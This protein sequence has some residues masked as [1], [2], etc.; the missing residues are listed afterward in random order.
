MSSRLWSVFVDAFGS[1]DRSLRLEDLTRRD[2]YQ[3]TSDKLNGNRQFVKMVNEASVYPSLI[4]EVTQRARGV[5]LWVYL[6]V[7]DL[8]RGLTNGDSGNLLQSRLEMFPEDLDEFFRHMITTIPPMYLQ[9]T[10]RLFEIVKSASEPQSAIALSFVDEVEAEPDLPQKS[11]IERM[12][13]SEIQ[14]RFDQIRRRLDARSKGLLEITSEDSRDSYFRS[15]I[16]FLHRTVYEFL[17]RSESLGA[18]SQENRFSNSPSTALVMCKAL[19]VTLKRA[20]G[21]PIDWEIYSSVFE[22]ARHLNSESESQKKLINTLREAES[23]YDEVY[24]YET[25]QA[26]AAVVPRFSELACA[27][28]ILLFVESE[29]QNGGYHGTSKHLALDY[30]LARRTVLHPGIIKTL[31]EAEADPNAKIGHFTIFGR[32]MGSIAVQ[33]QPAANESIKDVLHLLL[34]SGADV[35]TTVTSRRRV[36]SSDD[37]D[38]GI[39][40]LQRRRCLYGEEM[41]LQYNTSRA[42]QVIQDCF[43]EED[44]IDMSDVARLGVSNPVAA[45]GKWLHRAKSLLPRKADNSR[46]GAQRESWVA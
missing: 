13:D 43:P 26:R 29:L 31:L 6:V 1:T 2:I 3:Y 38:D 20:P 46:R 5:F 40:T 25:S 27:Y 41:W 33:E 4:E 42:W 37:G 24:P 15:R 30:A 19:V 8:L 36:L 45:T 23:V 9:H 12:A 35:N 17:H 16:D 10:I 34:S 22:W 44:L 32:F 21:F 7:R 11:L 18:M 28:G 14:W 39:E